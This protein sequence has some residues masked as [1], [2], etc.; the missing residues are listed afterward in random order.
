MRPCRHG[1]RCSKQR[2]YRKI[3]AMKSALVTVWA[4]IFLCSWTAI[5]GAA[6]ESRTYL[7][8]MTNHALGADASL[9]DPDWSRGIITEG[10]RS[11]EDITTRSVAPLGTAA[12]VLYDERNL[13]VAFKAQQPDVPIVANQTTNNVGFGLDDFVGVGI[14]TSGNG[15]T[16][17]YFETTPRGTRYQQASEST[18]YSPAWRTAARVDNGAWTA[19]MTIPLNALHRSGGS[20]QTWRFNF[21]RGVAAS[22]DHYTWAFDGTM[23][24]AAI[25][26]WP[27]F[28]DAQFWPRISGIVG[29]GHMGQ[30]FGERARADVYALGSAGGDRNLFAQA[31]GTFAPEHVRS[32]GADF[33]YALTSTVH[34]V[35]TVNPDF[36][37]VEVDQQTIAPQEF[38][39]PLV[40]YRPFFAQGAT[41]LNPVSPSA[42]VAQPN[43]QIF[44][45]PSI[46][47]FDRGMKVEG[48]FGDQSFGALSFRGYDETTGDEFDDVAYGYTHALPD[49]SFSYWSDGVFAHHSVAGNDATAEAGTQFHNV[50]TRWNGGIDE[51]FESGSW[52]SNP[53]S[54]RALSFWQAVLKPNQNLFMN[55]VDV[56]PN[57]NPIDGFTSISD[58]RGFAY[59]PIFSGSSPGLKS[60]QLSVAWDRFLDE[61]GAVHQADAIATL[62]AVLK[63][64]L[65]ISVGPRD[66]E[67]RSY[68][69][70]APGQ[71]GCGD[72]SLVRTSYTGF[73]NYYCGRTDRFN[74]FAVSLGYRNQTQSPVN[75]NY[76]EGPFGET[77]LQQYS[78]SASRPLG[79]RFSIATQFAGTYGRTISDGVLNS[80]WLRLIS[81]GD[82]LG[83][84]SNVALELRSVTGSVNGLTTV[85]G[86]NLAVS[87]HEK[88]VSGNE[89]YVAYGTPAATQTLNRFIIKY[90]LHEGIQN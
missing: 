87:F 66:G 12:Y 83:P 35:A 36:S 33:N 90:I 70:Q 72:A 44:Y 7:A 55:Y 14:D 52:V 32:M 43:N 88:F 47:P 51:A 17:Y 5:A 39:R 18:R 1:G 59:N 86:V 77:F 62:K 15:S 16:V 8:V 11:F 20:T 56:T 42:G 67:L 25:P 29:N 3:Q 30:T 60:Y 57:Y 34:F 19:V 75:F 38:K 73:P 79:S 46:G 89:L 81:F 64:Q 23:Q 49:Q 28:G 37:N 27:S 22:G 50:R 41:F 21:V 13:Y 58:T 4:V 2:T 24:D 80:Q 53:Y 40:E 82:N 31:N 65:S 26:R 74:Q 71:L 84:E 6:T 68:S 85:P 69:T 9:S 78:I 10:T 76:S 48:S 63:N 54:A 61:S 45:S